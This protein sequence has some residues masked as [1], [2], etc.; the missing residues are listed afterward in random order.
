MKKNRLIT[1]TLAIALCVPAFF[2][3]QGAGASEKPLAEGT[4]PPLALVSFPVLAPRPSTSPSNGPSGPANG[5]TDAQPEAKSGGSKYQT[6][7]NYH[8]EAPLDRRTGSELDKPFIVNGIILVNKQHPVS[9]NYVPELVSGDY[10]LQP[11]AD[12]ALRRM[13]EAASKEGFHLVRSSAY[14]SYTYQEQLFNSYSAAHGAEAANMFSAH[15][16]ESEHQ[17]GLAVDLTAPDQPETSFE[18]SFGDTPAGKWLA[19][20]CYLYGFILRY[21]KDKTNITGYI[22]EPWHFRYVG[23]DV[24]LQFGPNTTLT[25]EEYL[26]VA[27]RPE[28]DLPSHS[29]ENHAQ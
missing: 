12:A 28:T 14:R 13:M 21:P 18:E 16:G 27:D 29:R 24:A 19:A 11:T 3:L 26:G 6:P 5:E 17:T 15:P 1:K 8:Y 10:P 2:L 23:D 20:N 9:V 7:L 4:K 22:Y 25:L